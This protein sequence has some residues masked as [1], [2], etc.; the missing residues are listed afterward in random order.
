M[1]GVFPAALLFSGCCG[2]ERPSSA[3]RGLSRRGSGPRGQAQ[4]SA[5]R[6]T[7]RLSGPGIE[8][9]SPAPAG[10]SFTTGPPGPLSCLDSH[11]TCRLP[12]PGEAQSLRC[13]VRDPHIT[14]LRKHAAPVPDG[15]AGRGLP[16]RGADALTS[17]RVCAG[18]VLSGTLRH[19]GPQR[20]PRTRTSVCSRCPA[21][22]APVSPP[23]RLHKPHLLLPRP[24]SWHPQATSAQ[25]I[26][27]PN[28]SP[29]SLL[30]FSGN[31]VFLR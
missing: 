30:G 23:G 29:C 2:R 6:A 27:R 16:N 25:N 15:T 12:V 3:A 21:G 11:P 7:W 5:V 18:A 14:Q 13:K 20:V 9:P 31:R 22:P 10:R 28:V 24:L 19:R 8:P 1:C 26:P 17:Q 4:G